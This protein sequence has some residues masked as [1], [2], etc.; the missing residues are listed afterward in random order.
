M[1][2]S[3][4]LSSFTPP[5][6]CPFGTTVDKN[7]EHRFSEGELVILQ[8]TAGYGAIDTYFNSERC[9]DHALERKRTFAFA[10]AMIIVVLLNFSVSGIYI[11]IEAMCVG[12]ACN[13]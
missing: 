7:I 3:F 13:E 6:G 1:S 10:A 2:V 11:I 12:P 9:S 4:V 5:F 8:L